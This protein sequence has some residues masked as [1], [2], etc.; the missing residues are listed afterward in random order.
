[1]KDGWLVWLRR[2]D[3]KVNFN[4]TWDDYKQGFGD[5]NGSYWLGLDNLHNI[6]GGKTEYK[7]KFILEAWDG[8]RREGIYDLFF[9][10]GETSNFTLILR[11]FAPPINSVAASNQLIVNNY[12]QFSTR[13]RDNDKSDETNCARRG[14]WW[15][16]RCSK[17]FPTH[18]IGKPGD[19][20]FKFM[21]AFKEF[22]GNPS[23]AIKSVVMMMQPNKS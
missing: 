23:K 9:V 20:G 19:S 6:T 17:L 16:Q 1:M 7:L 10:E 18:P 11:E 2:V 12:Q 22:A 15:F 8:K 21:R 5:K 3:N 14:G 4:R 13:D